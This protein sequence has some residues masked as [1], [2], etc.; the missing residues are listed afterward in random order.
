M[1]TQP[2]EPPQEVVLYGHEYEGRNGKYLLHLEEDPR[3]TRMY[4]YGA[5][6]LRVE[7]RLAAEGEEPTLFGWW[8]YE[9]V[10][11]V[12]PSRVQFEMCFPYGSKVEVAAGAG[13]PIQLVVTKIEPYMEGTK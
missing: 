3:G 1:T 7:A 13:R 11:M 2:K 10:S 9:R 6:V 8:D 5:P 4:D 12:W